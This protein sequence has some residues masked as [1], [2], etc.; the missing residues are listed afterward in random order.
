MFKKYMKTMSESTR[1]VSQIVMLQSFIEKCLKDVEKYKEGK[2]CIV[3]GTPFNSEE[4]HSDLKDA[5][6]K[7]ALKLIE[8]FL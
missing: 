5:W 8:K 3:E 1:K 2:L 4:V 7:R 6:N